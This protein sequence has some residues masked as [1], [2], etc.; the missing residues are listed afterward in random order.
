MF[1][2]LIIIIELEIGQQKSV[3]N[4]NALYETSLKVPNFFNIES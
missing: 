4:E 1:L 2:L 3:Q